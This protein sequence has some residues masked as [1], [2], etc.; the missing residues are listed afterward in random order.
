MVVSGM[1]ACR[2]AE[3][4]GGS[5]LK[6]AVMGSG[7]IGGYVG[8]RLGEAGEEVH[9]IARGNH[10]AAIQANGLSIESPYGDATLPDIHATSEPAEI[11]PAD[12]ILF[13]VK[14]GDAD[15]AARSLKVLLVAGRNLYPPQIASGVGNLFVQGPQ[16]QPVPCGERFER[17]GL[18]DIAIDGLFG[19][20]RPNDLNLAP[21]DNF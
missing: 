16:P 17:G 1:V 7:G 11:G 5:T 6:I 2:F 15:R 10:L 18:A 4:L 9:L 12:L 3:K 13:T 14:L 20:C 21:G 8:G 19:D